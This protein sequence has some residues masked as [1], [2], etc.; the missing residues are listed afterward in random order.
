M[1]LFLLLSMT[2]AA[3]KKSGVLH[4]AWGPFLWA[5]L[6]L[7]VFAAVYQTQK[8]PPSLAVSNEVMA[9]NF[10]KYG[11]AAG[12]AF[13]LLWLLAMYILAGIKRLVRL[14]NVRFLNPLLVIL[15]MLLGFK[16]SWYEAY[17][18]AII[19]D[20]ISLVLVRSYVG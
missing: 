1:R 8:H 4:S 9:V 11:I 5:L 3:S 7:V 20:A 10:A 16:T 12:P 13:A 14:K 2:D 18:G 17:W 15:V 19:H 6:Y